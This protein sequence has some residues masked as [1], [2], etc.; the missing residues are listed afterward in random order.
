MNAEQSVSRCTNR[1]VEVWAAEQ[2]G[3]APWTANL[4][5]VVELAVV[6]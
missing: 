3:D 5:I 6:C 1:P 2:A 4:G